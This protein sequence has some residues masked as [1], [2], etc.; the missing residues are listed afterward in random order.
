MSH[1]LLTIALVM[2]VFVATQTVVA[3]PSQTGASDLPRATFITTMDSEFRRRDGDSDGKVTRIELERFEASAALSAARL[4]NRE[5]FSRLDADRNGALSQ[6]EFMGMLGTPATP[7]VGP[8]MLRLDAN[9]DQFVT[10]IEYRATTLANFDRLDADHD[11]VVTATEM[12]ANSGQP[13]PK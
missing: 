5:L 4:R 6:I 2:S 8:Q 13:L 3:Q 10:L 1:K 7:D 12:R 11:G 9:R